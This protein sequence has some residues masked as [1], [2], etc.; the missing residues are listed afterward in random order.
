MEEST[1]EETSA[2][3]RLSPTSRSNPCTP[4]E[5]EVSGFYIQETE[6]T[7][8]EID[9]YLRK[10]PE[11]KLMSW[12]K[13]LSVLIDDAKRPEVEVMQYPAVFI[14]RA[15]AQKYAQAV[16]GRLPTEAE[17]EY[18]ARSRG[19]NNLWAWKNMVAKKGGPK[20][21]LATNR[22][23][24]LSCPGQDL[25]RGRRDRPESLRYDGQR[26]GVVSRRLQT[27]FRTYRRTQVEAHR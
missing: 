21:H 18:A 2:T 12:K 5:V 6:V 15:T 20:A 25:R 9:A 13:G 11:A 1:F 22:N 16:D 24:A 14:D 26:A 23:R 8:K 7:N 27:L 19:Q 17:W 4:H 3:I 10:N